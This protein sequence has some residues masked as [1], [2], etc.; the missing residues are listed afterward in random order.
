MK[1][2]K[3]SRSVVRITDRRAWKLVNELLNRINLSQKHNKYAVVQTVNRAINKLPPGD[4]RA[5][6]YV[7]LGMIAAAEKDTSKALRLFRLGERDDPTD[8]SAKAML[9]KTLSER[10]GAEREALK[11]GQ[12]ALKLAKS[13]LERSR[14]HLVYAR[15]FFHMGQ[16]DDALKALKHYRLAWSRSRERMPDSWNPDLDLLEQFTKAGLGIS[17]CRKICLIALGRDRRVNELSFYKKDLQYLLKLTEKKEKAAL[18]V[19]SCGD[20]LEAG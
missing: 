6:V 9:A 1:T 16:Y 14:V 4:A 17:E 10:R 13:T 19:K 12:E 3:K 5:V 11:K 18:R 20:L 15:C 2:K 7:W 8:Y